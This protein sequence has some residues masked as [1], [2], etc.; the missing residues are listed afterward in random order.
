MLR[1]LDC[2]MTP[3]MAPAVVHKQPRLKA[4]SVHTAA[5]LLPWSTALGKRLVQ[6]PV[7]HGCLLW[8]G[9]ASAPKTT[10][11][12][13]FSAS[14]RCFMLWAA[15]E[16]LQMTSSTCDGGVTCTQNHFQRLVETFPLKCSDERCAMDALAAI[17]IASTRLP[18]GHTSS[19]R[20]SS[21]S[22]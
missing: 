8:H 7:P 12:A 9:L 18:T 3:R 21:E 15:I 10:G 20:G 4:A 11:T 19:S 16:S 13:A 17:F 14:H 2:K 5:E 22:V 6:T 1:S